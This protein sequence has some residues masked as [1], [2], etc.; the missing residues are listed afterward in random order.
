MT[1]KQMLE[2]LPDKNRWYLESIK[3]SIHDADRDGQY[4]FVVEM[5]SLG[6]GYIRGLVD[7]GVVDDFK[8]VWCWFT[9]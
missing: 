7:C 8:T 4:Q 1:T 3:K 6:R 5:K 9:L 2:K